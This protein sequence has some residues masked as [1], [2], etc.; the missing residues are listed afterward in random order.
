MPLR[1]SMNSTSGK[2]L[3]SV[4]LVGT[5]A[6][7]AGMGT[8]GTFSGSTNASQ[9]VSSDKVSITLGSTSPLQ[10][11]A[12]TGMLPGDSVE[13]LVTLKND[14]TSDLASVSL[15]TALP[16]AATPNSLTSDTTNGLQLTV[17]S[18]T[19]A[20]TVVANGPD[21]CAGTKTL[22][23]ATQGILGTD[24]ALGNLAAKTVGQSDY[25][26]IT[27]ALPVNADNTFQDKA[28]TVN[29]TFTAL[30]PTGAV[31]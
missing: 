15:T 18:C 24:L 17:E 2:I 4:A 23:V 16:A 10:I 19:Q 3:A 13:R 14:G 9:D 1:I 11:T 12:A 26:K 8:F 5:A 20:W 31:S 22:R 25:L 7:V 21:T 29:F 30:Q 27:T 6:A 28:A